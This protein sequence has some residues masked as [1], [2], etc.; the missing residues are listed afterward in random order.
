MIT[1]EQS[2]TRVGNPVGKLGYM[3]NVG[4]NKNGVGYGAWNHID[5]FSEAI[6][7]WMVEFENLR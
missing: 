4:S 5:G 1:D 3:V 6:V 7:D 2:H